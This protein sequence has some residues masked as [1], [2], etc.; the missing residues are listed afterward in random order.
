[1][2]SA[3]GAS[4]VPAFVPSSTLMPSAQSYEEDASSVVCETESPA[5]APR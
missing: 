3:L 1:M 5:L 4:A 2:T